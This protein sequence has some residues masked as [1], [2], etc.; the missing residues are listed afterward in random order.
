MVQEMCTLQV[1][2]A[3]TQREMATE[4]SGMTK[5]VDRVLDLI[6]KKLKDLSQP[7]PI[8]NTMIKLKTVITL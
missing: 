6:L 2:E 4:E 8:N 3:S 5:L 7:I 1:Q